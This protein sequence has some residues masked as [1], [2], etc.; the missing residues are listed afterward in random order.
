MPLT[1]LKHALAAAIVF[2]PLTMVRANSRALT[3]FKLKFLV[4]TV[5]TLAF[6]GTQA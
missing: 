5:G 4:R 1:L 2:T 6:G 3:L